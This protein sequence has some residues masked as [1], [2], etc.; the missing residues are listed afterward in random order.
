MSPTDMQSSPQNPSGKSSAKRY[1]ILIGLVLVVLVGWTGFWMVSK[2]KTQELID[3][4][5]ARQINGQQVATCAD[6]TLGGFPFRLLL[7]CSSYSVNDPKSGWRVEGGP[8]RAVWQVYAPNLAILE[9]DNLLRANH[10][11]SGLEIDVRATLIRA[12]VR[13]DQALTVSRF[14][15]EGQELDLQTNLP[16][17][18]Q[19]LEQITA[20]RLEIHGRANPE[21]SE[22]LDLAISTSKFQSAVIPRFSGTLSA[23][24]RKGLVPAI[25]TAPNPTKAWL[26]Q[27]GKLEQLNGFMTIGQKTLKLTGDLAFAQTGRADGDVVLKIL[28][29][30][31]EA[32]KSKIQLSAKDDGLNGP[33]TALQLMGKPVSDGDLIGSKV[34]LSIRD[35]QISAGFLPL[36][37]LPALK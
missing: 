3:K 32:G 4:V 17:V 11:A 1:F 19:S 5:L 26:E 34:D 21:Q 8:L 28:N 18:T 37:R 14:S 13:I 12:S 22:D 2:N 6:Q 30:K 9:G 33:L 36:G 29:P 31:P 27:A 7:T 23:T 20:E 16:A 10:A 35:G 15:V 24:A 25:L